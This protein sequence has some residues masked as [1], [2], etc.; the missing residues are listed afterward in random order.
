MYCNYKPIDFT[1]SV[2][3][4]R[5]VIFCIVI[6]GGW[7]ESS[8][9][10]NKWH[11]LKVRSSFHINEKIVLHC[12]ILSPWSP[13]FSSTCPVFCS[14]FSPLF[15][16]LFLFVPILLF[17]IY[18]FLMFWH[19]TRAGFDN[20]YLFHPNLLIPK[21]LGLSSVELCV[22]D[23][24]LDWSSNPLKEQCGRWMLIAMCWFFHM[25]NIYIYEDSSSMIEKTLFVL[26]N[27]KIKPFKNKSHWES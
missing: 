7:N 2:D 21:L 27:L 22:V 8:S 6:G 10:C 19:E 24:F 13:S 3:V 12:Q 25:N 9:V 18:Y 26:I 14:S 16:A 17:D 1:I 20:I 4:N 11:Y 15:S 5:C 23:L